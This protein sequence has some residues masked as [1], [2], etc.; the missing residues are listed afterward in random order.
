[1][2]AVPREELRMAKKPAENFSKTKAAGLEIA[3]R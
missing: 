2:G 1:L 3:Q